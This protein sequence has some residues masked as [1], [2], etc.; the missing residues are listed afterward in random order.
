MGT[1]RGGFGTGE[2]GLGAW[3]DP[4]ANGSQTLVMGKVQVDT[5]VDGWV[6]VGTTVALRR[7]LDFCFRE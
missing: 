1:R 7:T 3:C 6:I 2:G 4:R 5:G